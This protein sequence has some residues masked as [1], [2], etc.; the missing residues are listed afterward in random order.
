ME[1]NVEEGS[2][3]VSLDL[4]SIAATIALASDALA[5]AADALA[6]AA[7]AMSDASDTPG[8]FKLPEVL[9]GRGNQADG[10][11]GSDNKDGLETNKFSKA[12][13]RGV[14]DTEHKPEFERD[15]QIISSPKSWI[16]ISSDS[17]SEVEFIPLDEPQDQPI[18]VYE[19]LQ[20]EIDQDSPKPHD[21][22][23]QGAN[24]T[25]NTLP[26]SPVDLASNE[27]EPAISRPIL[28]AAFGDSQSL[29]NGMKSYPA[30]PS[31]RNYMYMDHES[32]AFAFIAYMTL[33]V[34]KIICL[35][36]D[37]LM[38]TCL[39]LVQSLT[40]ANAYRVN[41]FKH[42]RTLSVTFGAITKPNS[43]NVLLVPPF[44]MNLL[45]SSH[46]S[47]DCVLHWGPPSSTHRWVN[48][49]LHFIN[50]AVR[51]C[52]ML[53]E[54]QYFDGAAHGVVPYSDAILA[55]CHNPNSP[56][57][58]LRQ[59]SLDF[60]TLSHSTSRRLQASGSQSSS[61]PLGSSSILAP[62]TA[63]DRMASAN[64]LLVGQPL[65]D[66]LPVMSDARLKEP[67]LTEVM[68]SHPTIPPGRNYIHLDGPSDALA[69][70]AYMALQ[71]QRI[72]C[73]VP[74]QRQDACAKLLKSLTYANIHIIDTPNQYQDLSTRLGKINAASFDILLTPCGE[75]TFNAKWVKQSSPDCVLHWSHPASGYFFTT[76]RIVKS[77]PRSARTCVLVV[78]ESGF[79][80]KAH[81][82]EPYPRA[83]LDRCFQ[84]NSP[85]QLL[86]QFASQLVPPLPT[87]QASPNILV[88]KQP[89]Q[90]RSL[91]PSN[92]SGKTVLFPGGHYYSVLD[93]VNDIDIIS[94][95]AHIASNSKKIICHIPS[96]RD[97]IRFQ[98]LMTRITTVN[99]IA[100]TILGDKRFEETLKSFKSKK[101]G[102]WLRSTS[103]QWNSFWSKS[104]VDCAIY[105]G[106]PSDLVN[107]QV[108][109]L[110]GS[111]LFM[112]NYYQVQLIA[113]AHH[114][115]APPTSTQP[116]IMIAA[117]KT[118]EGNHA[119][120]LLDLGDLA[121]AIALASEA[122]AAAAEALAEA[123][124]AILEA[125]GTFEASPATEDSDPKPTINVSEEVNPQNESEIDTGLAGVDPQG[126]SQG[127]LTPATTVPLDSLDSQSEVRVVLPGS[128]QR[129]QPSVTR[130]PEDKSKNISSEETDIAQSEQ[131]NRL[132]TLPPSPV[133]STSKS[134][135]AVP[136]A[137]PPEAIVT[138]N[139]QAPS[140]SNFQTAM[141]TH[142][143][144]LPGRN[145]IHFAQASD[146][147]AFI[148]YLA[149]QANRTICIIPVELMDSYSKL[150]KSLSH[151]NVYRTYTPEQVNRIVGSR[152][153]FFAPTSY[154]IILTPSSEFIANAESFKR[155]APD[156]IMH[157]GEPSDTRQYVNRVLAPLSPSTKTCVM[158]IRQ[159]N[160]NGRAYGMTAY[161][162]AVLNALLPAP[163]PSVLTAP[164]ASS[165]RTTPLSSRPSS[166]LE[167]LPAGHFYIVLDIA[168]DMNL[169]PIIAYLST[170]HEKV[171]CHVPSDKFLP[172]YQRLINLISAVTVISPSPSVPGNQIKGMTNRL[173]LGR[174]VLLR[175]IATD[176]NSF[177]SKSVA[178]AVLYCGVPM[179][180]D[181]YLN[182]CTR[183]V[184][185]SY[186]VLSRSQYVDIEPQLT[187]DQRIQ[188]H[189][190][191][192]S[193]DSLSPG[194]LLH[195]LR[196]KL[197]PYL[198]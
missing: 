138:G 172:G 26:S 76:R 110:W 51:V 149:L 74:S 197:V 72:V 133:L 88:S 114:D 38:D 112:R 113:H 109:E 145:F 32:D 47:P 80:G 90:L 191:I 48:Q 30:I 153:D 89:P 173:K 25:L 44:F 45:S 174:G 116:P 120:A 52:V 5:A 154:H 81:E 79:D 157:W 39:E 122:L 105:W 155:V 68:K 140:F 16:S 143:M 185:H 179:D 56:F 171:I 43:C 65:A 54:R 142:P 19:S 118:G 57:Q 50:P 66:G 3:S 166:R 96:D 86:R 132:D 87:I 31:G 115:T 27:P 182:E 159:S 73:V 21:T 144:I 123:A 180:L 189:P 184:D 175:P 150:L 1:T 160:F 196:Q 28:D 162:T 17:D 41:S 63:H 93:E 70:I 158:L 111:V 141:K 148:V 164:S 20:H 139:P 129:E 192:R 181:A 152:L 92:S 46:I 146:A 64:A 23:E 134:E 168:N 77:L 163:T 14:A 104:L 61:H 40:G 108:I 100:P 106:I 9:S 128:R 35:V 119:S 49:V 136:P 124:R 84:S 178:N 156:C 6:E 59:M 127:I 147:L 12:N 7:R 55:T 102:I 151:A 60:L 85:L 107:S 34:H 194:H 22:L 126:E 62:A 103:T 71:A 53:V 170:K 67:K 24:N 125:S 117:N 186:L 183:K 29:G 131:N 98:T 99:I 37:S 18:P 177:F 78:N 83:I 8:T 195:D 58:L 167:S 101:S 121:A 135:N 36:P 193:P 188:Q 97:L 165:L 95:T 15:N 13:Q 169:I 42:F 10:L 11:E 91:E 198:R 176:W 69:F 82:V 130:L 4:G 33:Q 75:F 190:D 137:W 94:I 2:H 161:P 187:W